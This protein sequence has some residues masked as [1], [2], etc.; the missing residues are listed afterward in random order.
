MGFTPLEGLVMATRSG[1]ST[2]ARC[3]GSSGAAACRR[4]AGAMRSS[5]S[6]AC[7]GSP[8]ARA[9]C[10]SCWPRLD[11]GDA[12]AAAWPSTSTSTG[13]ARRSPR[14]PPRSAAST[15]WCSP[16]RRRRGLGTASGS[17]P[18]RAASRF[19]GVGVIARPGRARRDDAEVTADGS[20]VR[21]LVIHARE[22]LEIL[23]QTR[24]ALGRTA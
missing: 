21:T 10:A 24:A 14:W 5:T 1:S 23:R 20:R 18:R 4:R 16:A 22:D 2:R 6:P 9:T 13:C 11:A 19:L 7:S 15:R 12:R 3:S 17:R 8:A